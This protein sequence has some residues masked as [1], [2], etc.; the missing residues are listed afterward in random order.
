MGK[1]SPVSIKY[2]IN[3][4]IKLSG[5]AERPDVIGAIFGQTEGLLGDDLELRELQKSG[6]IGRIEVDLT[7]KDR[8]TQG[9]ILIPSSMGKSETALVGAAIETID[10]VG[11]SESKIRVKSIKDVRQSKRDYV[12]KRAKILLRNLIESQPDVKEM[13]LEVA[14]D[15]RIGDV[16]HY[17]DDKL[18]GGPDFDTSDEVII[19]EGRAD[20]VNLLR[21]GIK[22]TISLNG[23]KLPKTLPEL[24]KGKTITLFVD[25]DRGGDL[26]IKNLSKEIKI[27]LVTKAPDGKEVEELTQ[28]EIITALRGKTKTTPSRTSTT[29][30]T[31]TTRDTKPARRTPRRRTV[32]LPKDTSNLK[33][34]KE[35]IVGDGAALILDERLQTLGRVPVKELASTLEDIDG[36][37]AIV[38]DGKT[39]AAIIKAADSAQIKYIVADKKPTRQ[40]AVQVYSG[41]DL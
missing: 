14:E 17:G 2:N 5:L 25:G 26:I 38:M 21:Y 8:K 4:E 6:K 24:V 35:E 41:A 23:A 16:E 7:K 37:H 33:S 10:R 9:T 22:N 19:V 39:N 13:K 15:V 29:R 12:M 31:R 34:L 11:P 32:S 40:T 3:A 36:A 30:T 1:I 18:P 20:V 27:K 28:K